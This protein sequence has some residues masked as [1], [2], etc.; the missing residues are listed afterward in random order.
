MRFCTRSDWM[1]NPH[2]AVV[3]M[4]THVPMVTLITLVSMVLGNPQPPR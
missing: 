4:V 3:I 2:A 1:G